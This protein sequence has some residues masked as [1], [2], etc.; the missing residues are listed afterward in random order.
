MAAGCPWVIWWNVAGKSDIGGSSTGWLTR[1]SSNEVA[2][3]GTAR[4]GSA[5]R[6]ASETLD[7]VEAFSVVSSCGGVVL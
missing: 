5:V 7:E 4:P 1:R 2:P 6:E 3:P